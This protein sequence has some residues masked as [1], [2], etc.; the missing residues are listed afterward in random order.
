MAAPSDTALSDNAATQLNTTVTAGIKSH[1]TNGQ[2]VT[3]IGAMEQLEVMERLD[4]RKARR[5]RR[6]F[7]KIVLRAWS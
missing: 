6:P 2:T 5:A 7:Q 4:A 1:T 3:R